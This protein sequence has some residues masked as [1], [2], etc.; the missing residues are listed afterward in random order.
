[1]NNGTLLSAL[2][3]WKSAIRIEAI[4][5]RLNTGSAQCRGNYDIAYI[6]PLYLTIIYN[7]FM[8]HY[9]LPVCRSLDVSNSLIAIV[10]VLPILLWNSLTLN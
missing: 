6:Q 4:I 9:D 8:I 1:M 2:S 5:I 10:M 3:T 7:T